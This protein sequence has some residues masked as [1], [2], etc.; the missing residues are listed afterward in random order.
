MGDGSARV[1][2]GGLKFFFGRG[3]ECALVSALFRRLSLTGFNQ[4]FVVSV[5]SELRRG[6]ARLPPP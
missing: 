2:F 3:V 6:P 1:W 5:L 4:A